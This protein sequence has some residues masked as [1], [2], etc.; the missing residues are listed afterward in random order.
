[1]GDKAGNPISA[2]KSGFVSALNYSNGLLYSGGADG[3]VC[4]IDTKNGCAILKVV[5]VGTLVRGVD[6]MGGAN[7]KFIAGL[8][9]GNIVECNLA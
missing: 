1:M 8:K 7:G 4:L 5:N 9:N 6:G 3:N 2:H